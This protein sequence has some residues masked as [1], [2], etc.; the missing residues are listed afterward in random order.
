[1]RLY[2]VE[3]EITIPAVVQ[4]EASTRDQARAMAERGPAAWLSRVDSDITHVEA[5]A[6]WT[7]TVGED[8]MQAWRDKQEQER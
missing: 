3:V 6:A 2:E 1:M 4:V 7:Q 8:E 5:G